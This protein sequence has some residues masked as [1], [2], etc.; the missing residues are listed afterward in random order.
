MISIASSG[1]SRSNSAR[2]APSFSS[3]RPTSSRPAGG[4]LNMLDRLSSGWVA[5]ATSPFADE[6]PAVDARGTHWLEPVLVVDVDTHG[7]GH[8]RLRQP[9][10]RGLRDDLSPDDLRDQ[11]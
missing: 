5:R 10:Y 3:I 9:S 1:M 6:V 7:T 8:A 2:I 11:S 4:R